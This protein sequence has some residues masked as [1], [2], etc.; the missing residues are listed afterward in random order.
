[1]LCF[2]SHLLGSKLDV[3]GNYPQIVIRLHGRIG[4][5]RC[6]KSLVIP[7]KRSRS[8]MSSF[9]GIFWHLFGKTKGEIWVGYNFRV[10]WHL[11]RFASQL[12]ALLVREHSALSVL[13]IYACR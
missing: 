4:Y 13:I 1:M 6:D 5:K 3:S 7:D 11:V 12:S 9:V 8:G 2:H 10:I